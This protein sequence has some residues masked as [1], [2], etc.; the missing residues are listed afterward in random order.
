[1]HLSLLNS[2]QQAL[3]VN[4][5]LGTLFPFTDLST[6]HFAI[7][8][9]LCFQHQGKSL[10][11]GLDTIFRTSQ[12]FLQQ[13]MLLKPVLPAGHSKINVIWIRVIISFSEHHSETQT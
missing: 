1:M 10:G 4:D 2:W 6:I 13:L 12:C 8:Q 5:E 11:S 3:Q 9:E 7:E